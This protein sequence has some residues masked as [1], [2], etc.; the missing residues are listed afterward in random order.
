[1]KNFIC[2]CTLFTGL[3]FCLSGIGKAIDITEFEKI[4][5]QYGLPNIAFTIPILTWVEV[6]LGLFLIFRIRLRET[7]FT[8][9]IVLTSITLIFMYGYL[10]HEVEDCGCFGAFSVLNSS[11]IATLIRNAVLAIL[12]IIIFKNSHKIPSEPFLSSTRLI[13]I[14]FILT[15]MSCVI[16]LSGYTA[17]YKFRFH[18]PKEYTENYVGKPV[19][20]TPLK[21][22]ITTSK[23]STYFVFIFSYGCP[24]CYNSIENLKEYETSKIANKVIGLSFITDTAQV[25]RFSQIFHPSFQ[26]QHGTAQQLMKITDTFPVSYYITNDTI[27]M[28]IRGELPCAYVLQKQKKVLHP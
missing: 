3:F 7:A 12:L 6:A 17:H 16:Y 20:K 11:S 25:A 27:R 1:M 2:I 9:L 10:F 15:V 13:K 14:A 23:D 18:H 26:I 8:T 5:S 21:E 4:F 24:H 19:Y 28:R 22:L